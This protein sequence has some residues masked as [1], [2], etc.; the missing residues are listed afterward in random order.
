MSK[1]PIIQVKMDALEHRGEYVRE[2]LKPIAKRSGG[3]A[4]QRKGR[5]GEFIIGTHDGSPTQSDY[6]DWR[7]K[8]VAPNFQAMYFELWRQTGTTFTH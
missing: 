6:R 8:T 2:L 4:W 3:P 7:F 5:V 1:M